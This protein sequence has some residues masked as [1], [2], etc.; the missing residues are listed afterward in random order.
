MTRTKLFIV[1]AISSSSPSP[2]TQLFEV[3]YPCPKPPSVRIFYT[4]MHTPI[5]LISFSIY[6]TIFFLVFL[7]SSFPFNVHF[8]KQSY[9]FC[10]L[11]PLH[12][13]ILSQFIF[14]HLLHYRLYTNATFHIFV[15][16]FI[17]SC[18]SI[19]PSK[20]SHFRNLSTI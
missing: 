16:Y 17:F 1:K 12:M 9:C 7:S 14:S 11:S 8:H 3:G 15:L 10:F 2:F 5:A 13:P 18:H 6:P 4:F 20:H 19:H